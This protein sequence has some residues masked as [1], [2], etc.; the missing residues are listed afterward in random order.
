VEDEIDGAP[1]RDWLRYVARDEYK[2]PASNQ[3]T[4]ILAAAREEAV[5][6]DDTEP[7]AKEAS[8]EV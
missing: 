3:T 1:D 6:S 2:S 4:E 7:F 8:A 5:D